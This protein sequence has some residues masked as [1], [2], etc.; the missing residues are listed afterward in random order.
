MHSWWS[1]GRLATS[2]LAATGMVAVLPSAA[3]AHE[4]GGRGSKPVVVK[5]ASTKCSRLA[6]LAIKPSKIGLPTRGAT[7]DTATLTPAD[8][9]RPELCLVR[10]HVNSYLPT[11]WN[12]K[13]LQF[14]GGGFNGVLITGLGSLPGSAAVTNPAATPI[15]RGYVTFGGDGGTAVGDQPAGSFGLNP[16]SLANY[17]GE[18][19]K[20][21]RDSA[22]AIIGEYYR[23]SPGEQYYAGGSKGGHEGL[24]A[25]QRYGKDYDGIIAYYPAN[26]NQAMVLSWYHLLQQAYARPGGY[27]NSAKQQLL[28]NAVYQAC[29]GLDGAGDGVI[30]DLRGCDATF[31]VRSLRCPGGVDTGDTCVSDTQIGTLDAAATPYVFAFALVHGVRTLGSFPIYEGAD[32]GGIWMDAAGSGATTA[33]NGFAQ[34]VI[35]YFIKQQPGTPPA[36]DFSFDYRTYAARVRALSEQY[37]ATDPDVDTFARRGGKLLL[38]QGTIDMLVPHSTTTAYYRSLWA[39]YGP[40][41]RAFVRYYT[42][43]GYGHGNGRFNVAWDS[44]TALEN[45]SERGVAPG[46][47]VAFD[48]NAA[49]KD[50]SRPLCEYPEWPKYV[51]TGDVN[52]AA[53][54]RCVAR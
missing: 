39:R 31:D 21:T 41:A 46:R 16:E 9:T 35:Q 2:T 24:V 14:G 23:R 4:S 13:T 43:P 1:L 26:Q 27:L 25:A 40:L 18:S 19:V 11:S 29:D 54:F 50:R 6:G 7:V 22:V 5:D 30:A 3:T 36:T 38:V 45:W 34:P 52:Q 37:D 44:L 53:S 51:G 48:G 12:T 42:A 47:Q 15:N 32:P 10:G 49:T 28:V 8:A 20:R 33:Y 17:S